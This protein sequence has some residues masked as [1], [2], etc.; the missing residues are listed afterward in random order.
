MKLLI[1]VKRNYRA[2]RGG[3]IEDREAVIPR[4]RLTYAFAYI[5]K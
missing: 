3:V 5:N 2:R 4:F 1:T